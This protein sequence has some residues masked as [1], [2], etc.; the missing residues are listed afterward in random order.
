MSNPSRELL[1]AEA[2]DLLS[3]AIFI[4]GPDHEVAWLNQRA[5]SL[6]E[7]RDGMSLINKRLRGDTTAQSR[8]I[9]E[10]LDCTTLRQR[11]PSQGRLAL[12]RS[13]A[14]RSGGRPLQLVAT[15]MFD[16]DSDK[17]SNDWFAILLVGENDS[18]R[19]EAHLAKPVGEV[20]HRSAHDAA[21]R[22]DL[23]ILLPQRALDEL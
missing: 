3:I 13:V 22:S 9:D 5:R 21:V 1:L 7:S 18:Q 16:A 4:I 11:L 2:L 17:P 8:E 10:V 12:A 20:V 23:A 15:A 14:R 19:L 6:V